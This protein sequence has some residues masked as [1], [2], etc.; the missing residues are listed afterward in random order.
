MCKSSDCYNLHLKIKSLIADKEH[1]NQR[2]ASDIAKHGSPQSD[3]ATWYQ[4]VQKELDD[5]FEMLKD[6]E[7]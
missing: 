1:I 6:M 5:G 7:T 2:M 3:Y 4:E